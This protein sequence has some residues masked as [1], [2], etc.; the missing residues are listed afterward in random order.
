MK[1]Q[2][3]YD[4]ELMPASNSFAYSGYLLIADYSPKEES[5]NLTISMVYSIFYK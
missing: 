1:D 4:F 3:P 5:K 2:L